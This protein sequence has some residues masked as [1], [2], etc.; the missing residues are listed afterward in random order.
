MPFVFD[1][2]GAIVTQEIN[3]QKLPVFKHADGKETPFD[4]D[5]TVSTISRLNAEARSHREGKEAA[6]KLL[7]NFDGLDPV[8]AREA[9]DKLK[10]VDLNKLVD[11]G[12][13]EKVKGEVQKALEQQYA[14]ALKERD[15]LREQLNSHL[16]GGVFSGSK[17]VAEK[18]AAENAAV[19]AQIA[20]ALFAQNFKVEDGKVV[21][22]DSTGAKVYSRARPGELADTE[23]ALQLIVDASPLKASILKG[24][25]A[26]GGGATG[27]GNGGASGTKTLTRA[28]F[29][30]L[31]PASK[32]QAMRGGTQLTD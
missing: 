15:T 7:K 26:S 19:A 29:D 17:F 10:T 8:Q 28:A 32:A 24:S 5:S 6:E 9:L 16:I 1:A 3:G 14:P 25:G 13:V 21:A 2:N 31:D 12:E 11:K 23:E 4:A 18:F 27:G 20:R 22:Y 30:A